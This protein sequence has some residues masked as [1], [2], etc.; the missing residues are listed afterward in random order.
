MVERLAEDHVNAKYLAE[1][2]A[3]VHGIELDPATV[4]TNMVIFDLTPNGITAHELVD[5][6]SR[7]TSYYK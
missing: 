2:L 5:E 6:S 7:K 4:K 1:C 3:D